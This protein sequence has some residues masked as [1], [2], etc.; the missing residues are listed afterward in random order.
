M[1]QKGT[2]SKV[3][4]A[5]GGGDA[6]QGSLRPGGLGLRG[7]REKAEHIDLIDTKAERGPAC[8]A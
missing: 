5:A 6:R 8:C 3:S 4:G 2:L 1:R 7:R